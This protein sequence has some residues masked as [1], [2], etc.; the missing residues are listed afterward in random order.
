MKS[1][2]LIF[3]LNRETFY[4]RVLEDKTVLYSDRRWPDPWQFMPKD[5]KMAMKILRSRNK[6]PAI[7]LQW[8]NEANSGKNLEEYNSADTYEDLVPII[9]KDATNRGAL[10][11]RRIDE[12]E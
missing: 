2:K 5:E 6:I 12:D 4:L 3:T 8:I 1:I 10:F 7:V 11:Q 9:K